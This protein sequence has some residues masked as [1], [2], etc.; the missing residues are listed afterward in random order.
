MYTVHK[1]RLQK[2]K[3]EH[4]ESGL[5]ERNVYNRHRKG[6]PESTVIADTLSDQRVL[7]EDG[8]DR[9]IWPSDR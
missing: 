3:L 6:L 4:L 5:D 2:G 8:I 9:H 1:L 7:I